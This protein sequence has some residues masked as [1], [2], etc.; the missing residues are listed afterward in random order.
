MDIKRVWRSRTVKIVLI[1]LA[2]LLLLFAVWKV[3][4][5]PS[6]AAE[7]AYLPTEREARLACLLKEVEGIDDATAMI[8]EE[9]G[10]AVSAVIVFHG[11][12]SILIRSRVLDIASAALGIAKANVQVYP[13]GQNRNS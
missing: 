4:F 8:T 3:F 9:N 11:K 6:G 2:A 7:S 12:D 13:A 10:R 1:V 5:P